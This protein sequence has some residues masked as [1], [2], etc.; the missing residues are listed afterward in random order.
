MTARHPRPRSPAERAVAE[1]FARAWQA[2]DP[3]AI[4]ALLTDDAF[5]IMPPMPYR[6]DGSTLIK[7]FCAGLF[8]GGRRFL[9]VPT[10]A[11]GQPAFGAYLSMS[12]GDH[13]AVGLYVLTL[14]GDRIAALARFEPSS[15]ASFDL[16][17]SL[18]RQED[19]RHRPMRNFH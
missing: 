12:S 10:R 6:Y 11:N 16:P 4:V 19:V 18:A 13:P 1:R 15:L 9:L 14:R 5:M 3:D 7:Q 8:N 17:D 2:A